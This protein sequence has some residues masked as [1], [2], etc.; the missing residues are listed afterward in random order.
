MN[1]IET[2]KQIWD[3]DHNVNAFLFAYYAHLY[4]SFLENKVVRCSKNKEFYQLKKSLLDRLCS[5]LM[6]S[7]KTTGGKKLKIRNIVLDTLQKEFTEDPSI[8]LFK[9]LIKS[10]PNYTIRRLKYGSGFL[11]KMVK[12][13][14]SK[15]I[16]WFIK[17]L[18]LV[19]NK[20][21]NLAKQLGT[22]LKD[23]LNNSPKSGLLLAKK[24]CDGNAQRANLQ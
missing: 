16:S 5:R 8:V 3:N 18:A 14:I 13:S 2:A 17:N 22:E 19:V 21:S 7:K 12:L 10:V 11:T 9:A 4:P 15:K 23:L 20:Q 1:Y 24:Q 6:S